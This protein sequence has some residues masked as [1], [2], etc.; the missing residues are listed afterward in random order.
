MLGFDLSNF[1]LEIFEWLVF[2]PLRHGP[3]PFAKALEQIVRFGD[4]LLASVSL[5]TRML[6]NANTE[7]QHFPGASGSSSQ[8]WKRTLTIRDSTGE[9]DD[10]FICFLRKNPERPFSRIFQ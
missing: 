1:S 2:H 10:V 9:P 8:I 5:P 3:S 6:T 7:V 4:F